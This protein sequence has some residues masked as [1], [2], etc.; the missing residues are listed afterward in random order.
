[1]IKSY[2]KAMETVSHAYVSNGVEGAACMNLHVWLTWLVHMGASPRSVRRALKRLGYPGR[3]AAGLA[4][5]AAR[6]N[7]KF[8]EKEHCTQPTNVLNMH[9]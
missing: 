5:R 2:R 8:F 4:R 9:L 6:R 3:A 1:M 7:K